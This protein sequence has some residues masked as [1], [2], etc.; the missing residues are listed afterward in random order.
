MPKNFAVLNHFAALL[1]EARP[2]AKQKVDLLVGNRCNLDV[3][4]SH[5]LRRVKRKDLRLVLHRE[6][7]VTSGLLTQRVHEPEKLLLVDRLR[8]FVLALLL[9][10]DANLA[11]QKKVEVQR[12][13]VDLVQR[14]LLFVGFDFAE[15]KKLAAGDSV[16]FKD[17]L[18]QTWLP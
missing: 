6:C 9:Q 2:E 3:F 8:E 1:T 11:L 16:R 10:I 14:F 4:D 7:Q 12:L 17:L 5:V 15:T 18:L 13:F